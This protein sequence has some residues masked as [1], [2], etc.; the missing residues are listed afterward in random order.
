MENYNVEKKRIYLTGLSMGG[1]GTWMWAAE[2]AD[3][4]AAVAP[5]CGGGKPEN[6]SKY[7]KLPIWAFHG[8]ADTRVKIEKSQVMVDAIK[9]AGGNVKFTVYPGVKHNSWTQTYNNSELYKWF[10]SY[11]K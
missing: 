2:K 1:F 3:V 8:D 7:G 11:S 4:F 6:A 10:L 9:A 5:I